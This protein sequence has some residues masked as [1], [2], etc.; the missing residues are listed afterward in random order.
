M[1]VF[2]DGAGDVLFCASAELRYSCGV[3]VNC[4]I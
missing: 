3:L 2:A 1:V 4:R